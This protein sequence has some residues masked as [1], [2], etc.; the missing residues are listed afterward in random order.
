MPPD[1]RARTIFGDQDLLQARQDEAR[2]GLNL[3]VD[4]EQKRRNW[5]CRQGFVLAEI[6]AP[7]ERHNPPLAFKTL[8]LEFL[9]RQL[10]NLINQAALFLRHNGFGAIAKAGRIRR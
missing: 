2:S 3:A 5:I 6:V 1:R 8:K 4:V 10:R 9:E 7:T